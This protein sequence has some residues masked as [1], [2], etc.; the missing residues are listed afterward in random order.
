MAGE[1]LAANATRLCVADRD[2][3][4]SVDKNGLSPSTVLVHGFLMPPCIADDEKTYY[5]KLFN[6]PGIMAVPL[7]D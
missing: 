6:E 4:L 2:R 7:F 5:V 1:T 3:L